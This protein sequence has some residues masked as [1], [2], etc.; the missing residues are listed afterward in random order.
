MVDILR[1]QLGA[2][3]LDSHRLEFEHHQLTN[4]ILRERLIHPQTDFSAWFDFVAQEMT[5]D[6]FLRHVFSSHAT[7]SL[8]TMRPL[9][10]PH[11]ICVAL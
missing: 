7:T 9:N 2:H 11:N 3:A 5:A 8:F 10:E 4:G 1:R 6:Q